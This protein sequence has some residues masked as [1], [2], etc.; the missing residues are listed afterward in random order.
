M[1]STDNPE[2]NRAYERLNKEYD[3]LVE[4]CNDLHDRI[5]LIEGRKLPL[6]ELITATAAIVVTLVV[7]AFGVIHQI[8]VN[9]GDIKSLSTAVAGAQEYN[10]NQFEILKTSIA[11]Q[12]SKSVR[13]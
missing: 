5:V 12:Q 9:A 6:L 7:G 10:K 4:R 11:S 3:F 13:K 2:M 1:I 8:D